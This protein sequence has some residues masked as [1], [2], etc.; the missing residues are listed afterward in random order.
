MKINQRVRALT[1]GL[2][3]AL[4][5]VA[6]PMAMAGE[7]GSMHMDKTVMVGGA[8]MYPSKNIIQNA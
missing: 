4:A 5:T 8:A 1:V 3:L 7:M 6:A 2:C